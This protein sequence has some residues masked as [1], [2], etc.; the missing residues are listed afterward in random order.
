[1]VAG[2]RV[3]VKRA[4]EK[5]YEKNKREKRMKKKRSFSASTNTAR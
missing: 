1:M 5:C 2:E 4:E 3:V